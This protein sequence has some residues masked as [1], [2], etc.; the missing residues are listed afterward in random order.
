MHPLIE[1]Y[2]YYYYLETNTYTHK[3]EGMDGVLTI[4]LKFKLDHPV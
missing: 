2:Y 4:V 1:L 3:R